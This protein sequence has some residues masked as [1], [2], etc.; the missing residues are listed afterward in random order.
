MEHF[1]PYSGVW[2][3]SQSYFRLLGLFLAT[4]GLLYILTHFIYELYFS[5]LSYIPGPWYAAISDFWLTTRLMQ[6][7]QCSSVD[8]LFNRYGPVV[9]VGPNKVVFMD[10]Q[11]I[12]DVY[13]VA[14]RFDKGI[15]YKGFLT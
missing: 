14:A 5:P 12:K 9:R 4:T 10:A 11:A 1:L 8:E 6:S 2:L 13:G 3:E 7:R 15:F